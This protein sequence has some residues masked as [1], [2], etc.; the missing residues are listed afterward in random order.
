VLRTGDRGWVYDSWRTEAGLEVV[1]CGLRVEAGL[2]Q[3]T[4]SF[5]VG[6]NY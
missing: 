5:L 3:N 4:G 2:E 1:G 6:R